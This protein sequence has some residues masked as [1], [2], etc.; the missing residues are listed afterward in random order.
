MIHH[1][2]APASHTAYLQKLE[3]YKLERELKEQESPVPAKLVKVTHKEATWQIQLGN[4]QYCCAGH[5][6]T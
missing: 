6:R 3:C 2:I 4:G 5:N 1:K